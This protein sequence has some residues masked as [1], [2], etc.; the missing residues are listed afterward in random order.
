MFLISR[1]S[2]RRPRADSAQKLNEKTYLMRKDNSSSK[3]LVSLSPPNAASI[4]ESL[5]TPP[6]SPADSDALN[7]LILLFTYE[8]GGDD[9]E[10]GNWKARVS[11]CSSPVYDQLDW[12]GLAGILKEDK[13]GLTLVSTSDEVKEQ[14][15]PLRKRLKN[16]IESVSSGSNNA[17]S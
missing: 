13:V 8:P 7:R 3:L 12:D 10:D 9:I 16:F 11:M 4:L 6:S 14:D 17:N 5:N 1:S 15:G 2:E